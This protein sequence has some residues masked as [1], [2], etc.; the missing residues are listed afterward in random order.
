[1]NI[2]DKL[3]EIFVK[4]DDFCKD[5]ERYLDQLAVVEPIKKT[6]FSKK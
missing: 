4:R 5:Y 3:V 1:M 6:L 2:T